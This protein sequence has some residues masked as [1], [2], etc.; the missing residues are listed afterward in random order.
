MIVDD[1]MKASFPYIQPP[2]I[3][4]YIMFQDMSHKA[5]ASRAIV[6]H[7]GHHVN[8]PVY[9]CRLS[10]RREG[11]SVTDTAQLNHTSR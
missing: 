7:F 8:T 5:K 9:C 10:P 6:R 3:P 4:C 1:R 11:R 2:F